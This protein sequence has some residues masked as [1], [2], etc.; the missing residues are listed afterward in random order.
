[1]KP[2]AFVIFL[3]CGVS[4][5]QIAFDDSAPDRSQIAAENYALTLSKTNGGILAIADR[6]TNATLAVTSPNGC[7][8]G[9][10][11]PG[12]STTYRGGCNYGAGKPDSFR[13]AWDA[14]QNV[15]TLTYR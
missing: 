3:A 13:Y 5:A 9:S 11:Y 15:L 14:V 1:V 12:N 8:W 10:S 6:T 7:F 2:A 4:Q